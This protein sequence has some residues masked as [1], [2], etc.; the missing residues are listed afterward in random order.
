MHRY[1]IERDLPGAG[2]LSSNELQQISKKSNGVLDGMGKQIQ[3]EH[4]YVAGDKIYCVYLADSE[5][6]V[7]Q[8]A[9]QGG[10]PANKIT[11][12]SAVIDPMSAESPVP[13]LN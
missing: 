9:Q 7:R 13:M 2:N 6:L 12:V 4:S 5:D 11:K 10:F 1:I 3:W 8:H